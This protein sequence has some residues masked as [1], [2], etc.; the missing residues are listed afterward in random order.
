MSVPRAGALG[1]PTPDFGDGGPA[2][3]ISLSAT[4]APDIFADKKR[5][6][7]HAKSKAEARCDFSP[8]N[9]RLAK[10]SGICYLACWKKSPHGRTLSEIK[11]DDDMVPVFARA[12]AEL[13]TRVLGPGLDPEQWAV[14]TC[15]ARR[16]KE[17][18]FAHMFTEKTA[19]TL[20]LPFFPNCA[21][22]GSKQR[23]GAVF[24][25]NNIPPQKNIIVTDDIVTT[26]ST[27]L[28]MQ[29][30]LRKLGKNCILVTGINN[31]S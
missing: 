21:T 12:V 4:G 29:N 7:W 19:A 11:A 1:L 26:G 18:N 6:G 27:M 22:A 24:T 3:P 15:P 8:D 14:V 17:R 2:A 13:I 25:P 23:V 5:L 10:K 16:H 9:N 30:M 28:A 20:G 31:N